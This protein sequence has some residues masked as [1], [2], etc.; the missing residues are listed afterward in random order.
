MALNGLYAKR[1][2]ASYI[3]SS[4]RY[5]MYESWTVY[6]QREPKKWHLFNMSIDATLEQWQD[7][8][9]SKLTQLRER[10]GRQ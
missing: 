5:V 10:E 4:G 9:K 7:M 2:R 3:A 6:V 8:V 1:V